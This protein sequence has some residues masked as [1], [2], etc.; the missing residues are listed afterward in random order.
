MKKLL[1]LTTLLLFAVVSFAYDAKIDGI[2]YVFS[3]YKDEAAV[4]CS[5]F[6]FSN[7]TAYTGDIIIPETVTYRGKIYSVTSIQ[8]SAFQY[9]SNLTSITIPSSVKKIEEDAF[10]GCTGLTKVITTDINDWLKIQFATNPSNPLLY[11]NHLYNNENTEITNLVIPNG[12]T[13]INDYAFAGCSGLTSITIPSSVT[14]IGMCAFDDCTGLTSITIPKGVRTIGS[15][16]FSG[17]SGLTSITLPSSVTTIG[18]SVF[19]GCSK[20]TSITI[21][22]SVKSIG[23]SAFWNCSSLTSVTIPSSVTTIDRYAFAGCSGLTSIIIPGNVWKIDDFAFSRCEN[24]IT[25]TIKSASIVQNNYTNYTIESIFGSQ[26]KKYIL[27]DGI[28]SIGER[29]F[30]MCEN[31]TSINI[32][33]NITSI[34]SNAFD[35]CT[36]LKS[37]TIDSDAIMSKEHT[38]KTNLSVLFGAQVTDYTI[39]NNVKKIGDLAFSGCSGLTSITL[40]SSVTTIGSSAFSGCSGLTSITIPEGVTTIGERAFS[41]CTGLTKVIVSDIA[42]WCSIS[43]NS[44]SS[45]PLYYAKHL[46]SDENSEITELAIP[47]G[48]TSIGYAA[49]SGCS[50]LT[51]VTIPESVTTIG[52]SAFSGCSGLTSITIPESVTTIGGSAFS[53]CSGLTSITIPEGVTSIDKYAFDDCS[54]LTSITIPNSVTSIGDWAFSGCSGLTSINIPSNVTSI[55]EHTFFFCKA[56]TEVSLNSNAIVSKTYTSSNSLKDI[57]GTQV[58]TY[59]LGSNITD[60]GNYA[61]SGSTSLT[62]ITIPSSVTSIGSSAFYNCSN[63]SRFY[64]EKGSKALIM[65]WEKQYSKAKA[66]DLDKTTELPKPYLSRNSTQTSVTYELHNYYEEYSYA[67][68]QSPDA[69]YKL[70][71]GTTTITGLYPGYGEMSFYVD[72]NDFGSVQTTDGLY[73]GIIAQVNSSS[74]TL[75]GEY[76]KGNAVVKSTSI[77]L[78]GNKVDGDEITLTA[79]KPATTYSAEYSVVIAYGENNEYTKTYTSTRNVT[80]ASLN[81]GISSQKTASSLKVNGTYTK[82]DANIVSTSITFN[83]KTVEGDEAIFTGLN[84]DKK[85][86]ATYKVTVA[87]GE[88][89]AKTENFTKTVDLSTQELTLTTEQPKVVSMGNVVVSATTNVD[90]EEKNVG[91]EWRRTDWTSDFAS[92]SGNA[93]IFDNTMEGYIR[94][95]NT[96]KLWTYRA[97]YLSDAGVYYYGDWVGLD[98]SNTSYFEP[99][100]HTYADISTTGNVALIRGYVLNGTDKIKVQGFKYWKTANKGN[101]LD[102]DMEGDMQTTAIPADAIIK[103][104]DIVGSGQQLMNAT[105]EGLDYDATYHCVA[106]ATTTEN[107]TFYGEE[108]M[109]TTESITG[110]EGVKESA[111][112]SSKAVTVVAYYDL[113]GKRFSQPQKGLNIIRMSDGTTRKVVK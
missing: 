59:I 45:N 85:Y 102:I 77:T 18:S 27:G 75:K 50:G 28:T 88:N 44:Y 39:G 35:Y 1:T 46:Y 15:S 8:Y 6:S 34:G 20:L 94:N 11:A 54:G 37:V 22:S 32:P 93:V 112:G 66:Y 38:T 72:G 33:K 104:V 4:S 47:D 95:L 25:V 83:G 113:N 14:S 61:F 67:V 100:V 30:Y 41:G 26:V 80:T 58:K 70:N 16:A 5:S 90:E 79:L 111:A 17:C 56:L 57:F 36:S 2:Y 109:F 51:S 40:P 103:T 42:K 53:G 12:V 60:I 78:G 107:E 71:K 96:D 65:V 10:S 31:L 21:P 24:L 7:E 91:F 105:L 76:T 69:M 49:F 64:V 9:C 101:S 52:G 68:G 99:T 110:I 63:L 29:A 97:Y 106:F 82:G 73:P 3:S 86:T 43:F 13:T 62:N 19:S 81:L 92:N 23:E 87:Y 108:Q 84:P 98:A 89:Y 74:I 55:Y 48:V